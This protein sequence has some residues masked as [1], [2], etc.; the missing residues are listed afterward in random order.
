MG[1]IPG[2]AVY[3]AGDA[4]IPH[5]SREAVRGAQVAP[6]KILLITT[7]STQVVQLYATWVVLATTLPLLKA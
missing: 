4:L 6:V 7:I 1:G 3:A 2:A 5:I